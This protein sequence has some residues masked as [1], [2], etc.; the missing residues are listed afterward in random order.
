MIR[1]YLFVLI[2]ILTSNCTKTN[3]QNTN[4][5]DKLAKTN[6]VWKITSR[7]T[8]VL[9]E[10]ISIELQNIS[11]KKVLI[12]YPSVTKIEQKLGEKWQAIRLRSYPCL[13]RPSF[14]KYKLVGM[15]KKQLYI[16]EQKEKWCEGNTDKTKAVS[17]GKYRLKVFYTFEEDGAVEELLVPFE[18]K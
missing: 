2:L 1:C 9:G 15:Q 6:S 7:A 8:Y 12:Q 5:T 14:R 13:S 10:K 17:K 11:D 18:I 4:K 3:Y 16:W